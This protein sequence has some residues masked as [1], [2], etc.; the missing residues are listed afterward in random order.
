[1][2]TV[3][4][5]RSRLIGTLAFLS[6]GSSQYQSHSFKEITPCVR[7]QDV[8]ALWFVCISALTSISW[9]KETRQSPILVEK[10]FMMVTLLSDR[11]TL[12]L[13]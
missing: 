1:M 5:W 11:E 12:F 6:S 7:F 10:P 3:P 4:A 9:Y 13:C 2:M 8:L